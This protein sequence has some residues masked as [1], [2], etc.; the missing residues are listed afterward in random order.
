[1]DIFL[2]YYIRITLKV[3]H[4]LIN[5]AFSVELA[6]KYLQCIILDAEQAFNT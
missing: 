3:L 1:M 6:R 2:S 5:L 4:R